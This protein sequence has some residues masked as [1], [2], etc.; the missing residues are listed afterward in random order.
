MSWHILSKEGI[1]KSRTSTALLVVLAGAAVAAAQPAVLVYD[2]STNNQ[3]AQTAAANLSPS[4]TVAGSADFNTQLNSQSWDLVM[5]DCPGSTPSGGWTD[6]IA[7]V[8]GGGA[9]VMSFWDW[10]N[11]SS[12]GDPGLA[13][14]FGFTSATSISLVDTVSTLSAASTTVGQTI[15]TGVP[16]MPH[17]SWF[18]AWIDDGDAF[19]F[20]GATAV[21]DLSDAANPVVILN[22]SGNAIAAFLIDEW[23]GAGAVE[24]W[25]N[26][27]S[28][29][30]G[31]T[32]VVSAIPVMSPV[33]IVLLAALIAGVGAIL[34]GRQ[35]MV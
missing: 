29:L 24:F 14:A 7:F 20:T 18:N 5:V 1:V 15:F 2:T 9:T 4:V 33:G 23:S 21:A 3:Y 27:G 32:E 6:L 19:G 22:P 11:D 13:P 16:G 12:Q 17:S 10:D 8:N 30:L 35:R 31:Q 26:M 28:Y 34:I 25:E